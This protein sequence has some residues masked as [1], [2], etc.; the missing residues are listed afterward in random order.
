FANNR[1]LF[2][3]VFYAIVGKTIR[4]YSMSVFYEKAPTPIIYIP[5]VVSEEVKTPKLIGK[6]K[7]VMNY[8]ARS[9]SLSRD[10]SILRFDQYNFDIRTTSIADAVNFSRKLFV[11]T[12]SA[13]P[14]ARVSAAYDCA[15]LS[16]QKGFQWLN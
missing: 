6:G 2:N 12:N 4:S 7:D 5:D 8:L 14:Q 11:L 15:L 10:P 3:L 16:Y 9:P 13:L 1:L